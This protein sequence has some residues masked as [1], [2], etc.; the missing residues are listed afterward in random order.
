VRSRAECVLRLA[1]PAGPAAVR[2]TS[3]I[4]RLPPGLLDGA[5]DEK[6]PAAPATDPAADP[7]VALL[8][9]LPPRWVE[10]RQHTQER[11]VPAPHFRYKSGRRQAALDVTELYNRPIKRAGAAGKS[12]LVKLTEPEPTPNGRRALVRV[13]DKGSPLKGID[14]VLADIVPD[15]VTD[16]VGRTRC[17]CLRRCLVC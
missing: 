17:P 16:L 12:V 2:Q 4:V 9:T 1:D 10:V 5:E 13:V 3:S 15:W 11:P 6:A 8:K 7:R 14:A